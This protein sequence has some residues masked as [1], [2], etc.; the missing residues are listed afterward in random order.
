M[1]AVQP[2]FQS[3]LKAFSSLTDK[4]K[5]KPA[6]LEAE[7]NCPFPEFCSRRTAIINLNPHEPA[8]STHPRDPANL[9]NCQG[10]RLPLHMDAPVCQFTVPLNLKPARY[11]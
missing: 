11:R 2:E 5:M 10:P 8:L 6:T 7:R 3:R 1:N 9:E 4:A